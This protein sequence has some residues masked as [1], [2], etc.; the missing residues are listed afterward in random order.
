MSI[1]GFSIE[2]ASSEEFLPYL[3]YNAVSGQFTMVERTLGQNGFENTPV[4][5]DRN[6]IKFLA[7]L[8]NIETGWIDFSGA[9]PSMSLVRLADLLAGKVAFPEKPSEAHKH[10]VRLMI[11]LAKT[12]ATEK[13]IRELASTAKAFVGGA[14]DLYKLYTASRDANQGLLPAVMLDGNPIL[15]KS[16]SGSRSSTAYRP[17][18]KIVGW[19]PRGDLTYTPRKPAAEPASGNGKA[20]A[21]A[22]AG[23]GARPSTGA[24]SAPPPPRQQAAA[25]DFG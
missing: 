24:T 22:A 17:R 19:A 8:E 23:N 6:T 18:F 20:A 1:F 11:K 7:D 10:G 14:E 13:P 25:D 16:G 3:K 15:Q 21:P 12:V 9:V 4:D 2:P 5:L